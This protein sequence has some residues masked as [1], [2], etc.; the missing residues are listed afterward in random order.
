MNN[1]INSKLLELLNGVDPKQLEQVS[2]IV[3]NMSK[4]D[5]ENLTRMLG[6]KPNNAQGNSASPSTNE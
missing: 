5:I 2:N 1:M 4:Q 3:K 6:V